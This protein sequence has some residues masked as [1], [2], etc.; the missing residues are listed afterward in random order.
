MTTKLWVRTYRNRPAILVSTEAGKVRFRTDD[1]EC[2]LS[3]RAWEKLPLCT[4]PSPFLDEGKDG[5][6]P[7]RTDPVESPDD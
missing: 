5:F 4:G 1:K 2:L 7:L 6:P 3:K